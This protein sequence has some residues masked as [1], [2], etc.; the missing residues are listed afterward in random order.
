MLDFSQRLILIIAAF[1][2]SCIFQVY[3]ELSHEEKIAKNVQAHIQ[4]KDF[5]TASEVAHQGL[6]QY[7]QAQIIWEAYILALA[8]NLDEKNMLSAWSR[9]VSLYP[10]KRENNAI[11]ENLAWGIIEK[12]AESNSP[13]MR[14]MAM[15]AGFFSQDAKG[16]AILH[17]NFQDRSSFI[18]S[19][20]I[21]L[22]SYLHD[23]KLKDAVFHLFKMEK[24]WSVRIE[25]IKAAGKMKIAAAKPLLVSIVANDESIAEEKVAAIQAIISL[26]D[27]IERDEV[28]KLANS[29]RAG[30]RHLACQVVAHFDLIRDLDLILPLL[31]DNHSEVRTAALE[32]LGILRISFYEGSSVLPAISSKLLDPDSNVAVTAAWALTLIDPLQGQ[33]AFKPWFN[34][35]SSETR[36]FASS[37]LSACGKYGFPLTL[38]IFNETTDQYVKMNLAFCLL[39]QKVNPSLACEALY[40]GLI[41]EKERWMWEEKSIFRVLAPSKIKYDDTSLQHPE[42]TNQLARL[43]ILNILAMMQYPHAQEAIKQFLKEKNWEIISLASGVLLTEGDESALILVQNLLNDPDAKIRIQAA[44]T[45]AQWGKDEKSLS[46][47]EQAYP[48]AN[49]EL[50]EK[51]LE[52]ILKVGSPLSIPF[53][54]DRLHD[55]SQSI[56]LI[57][58][59][60]LLQCLYN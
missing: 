15:L 20:A 34:H 19:T 21:E 16:I 35:E 50:K 22:S 24:V 56:R 52:G 46:V 49:R 4:I 28:R 13:I 7:P 42:E 1:F 5:Q 30:L 17:R 47:L 44:L 6:Q 27:T 55:P 54:L 33:A 8:K 9:Y 26:L 40:N 32:T 3:A 29:D 12:A 59:A 58:A 48:S 41:Q 2:C 43:E 51:I 45:L 31:N 18:R 14:C 10:E 57:A 23:D 39:G 37:A 36:R 11:I 25:A 60:A 53:L 38:T